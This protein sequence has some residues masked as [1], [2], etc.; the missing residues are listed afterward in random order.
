MIT[1]FWIILILV[2]VVSLL[3][4]LSAVG[5]GYRAPEWLDGLGVIGFIVLLITII[6]AVISA[7]ALKKQSFLASEYNLGKM[8][9][10]FEVKYHYKDD[11]EEP[12]IECRRLF[13]MEEYHYYI[14]N[15]SKYEE[16][17]LTETT[18]QIQETESTGNIEVSE[19]TES[20][21][22]TDGTV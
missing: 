19:V 22:S 11:I 13:G 16:F 1:T 9:D 10:F 3:V 15:N 7:L 4:L 5:L 18:E 2:G 8:S 21:E 14:P 12:Y 20:T 6:L 17:K